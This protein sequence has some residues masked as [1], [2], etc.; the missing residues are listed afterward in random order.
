[1]V[2]D[3]T[4]R[5]VGGPSMS[6]LFGLGVVDRSARANRF[7]V[8]QTLLAD[9]TKLALGKL[10]LS[11]ALGQPTLRA[12]DG[13]GALAL[14]TAGDVSTQFQA[15]GSLGLVQMTVSRYA[16][17]F[18]GSVGRD[19][20]A[21]ETRKQGAESVK[22]EA[23]GRRQAVEGVNLDEELVRL[24]SYQQAFNASARMIQA[25]SDLFEVLVKMV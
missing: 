3:N 14:S 17:E 9:P 25:A 24:Q 22:A 6:Q 4:A 23:V 8:S 16:S 7:A 1:V 13:R 11:V 21:A 12:G 5:G 15:A 20:A 18:G 19:A 10:D 2:V